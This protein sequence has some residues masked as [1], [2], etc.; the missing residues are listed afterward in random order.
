MSRDVG[1]EQYAEKQLDK[2]TAA[3]RNADKAK[4]DG[5]L[6][7][8]GCRSLFMSLHIGESRNTLYV[9]GSNGSRSDRSVQRKGKVAEQWWA[10][11]K[12]VR[13]NTVMEQQG[14]SSKVRARAFRCMLDGKP[15]PANVQD[16]VAAY[17][18]DLFDKFSARNQD[19]FP[20]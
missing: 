14:L 16:A 18:E 2:R 7:G 13:F 20:D 8:K 6:L 1:F 4:Q 10:P 11:A 17:T 5:L 3:F 9:Q 19:A 12:F 15:L